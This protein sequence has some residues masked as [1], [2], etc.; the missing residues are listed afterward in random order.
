MRVLPARGV[1]ALA[2]WSVV[3]S[4]LVVLAALA[5]VEV[6][7][8]AAGVV[9]SRED[10]RVVRAPAAGVVRAVRVV[11]G[12]PVSAG[13][14]VVELEGRTVAAPLAGVAD[15]V[16]A[17]AGERVEAGDPLVKLV[18]EGA[19][20]VATL[21]VPAAERPRVTSGQAVRLRV[22]GAAHEGT[23]T[24]VARDLASPTLEGER[25]QL[26]ITG[27]S[28]V[29]EVALADGGELAAGTYLEGHVIVGRRSLLSLM[30][31]GAG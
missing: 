4:T 29:V 22:G 25:L 10:V 31:P 7:V 30:L 12:E 27:P 2:L 17:R 16:A 9:R 3:A 24:R 28:Y 13:A 11:A 1:W 21:L 5:E 8:A 26:P 18:P 19:R 6:R 15:F 14:T 20:P 23:V